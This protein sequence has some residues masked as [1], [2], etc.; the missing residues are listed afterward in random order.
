MNDICSMCTCFE[1]HIPIHNIC[2]LY[3]ENDDNNMIFFN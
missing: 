2:K 3:Y 1:T